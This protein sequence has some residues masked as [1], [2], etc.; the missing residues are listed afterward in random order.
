MKNNIPVRKI[1]IKVTIHHPMK[2]DKTVSKH[3]L[4]KNLNNTYSVKFFSGRSYKTWLNPITQ[5]ILI[6]SD[7]EI[8]EYWANLP[9]N[10][11]INWQD[12]T[13]TINYY[14]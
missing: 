7:P 4:V 2:E 6:F 11:Q 8:A 10:Y 3:I 12:I 14:I 1:Q 5:K 13:S 9:N